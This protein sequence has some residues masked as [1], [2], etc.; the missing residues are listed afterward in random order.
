[1]AFPLPSATPS[2]LGFEFAR[3]SA[4]G[5]D[6]A[7]P[8]G[9]AVPGG[10]DR[11]RARGQARAGAGAS[12][13]PDRP[14]PWPAREDS[15]WLLYSN[16]KVITACAVWILAEQGPPLH[17]PGG[18]P[19]AGLR[20]QWQGRHHDH[21]AP[22][23]PGRLSQRGGDRRRPGRTTSCCAG[24]SRPSRSSGRP[25]RGCT[26]TAGPRTGWPRCSSRRSARPTTG[27]SSASR[28]SSR[29]GS[30][31]SSSWACPTPAT[32]GPWTCTSPPRREPAR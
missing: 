1:M 10:A 23:P 19:R 28:S 18:R 32:T 29:S 17:G 27:P 6:H 4:S 5:A 7:A 16:T 13:M 25:A 24:R 20:G 26:T 21:P 12:V 9:R 2:S 3:S 11:G 14:L 15:L 30:A 31:T 8:G 22:E